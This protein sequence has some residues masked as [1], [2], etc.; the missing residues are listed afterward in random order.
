MGKWTDRFIPKP[1]HRVIPPAAIPERKEEDQT[2]TYIN[3]GAR[4]I[5]VKLFDDGTTEGLKRLIGELELA[6]DIVKSQI[7]NWHV[8][9]QAAKNLTQGIIVPRAN[10]N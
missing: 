10:G 3:E 1:Q 5:L 9:E 7:S 8:R 2:G 6:K 4:A